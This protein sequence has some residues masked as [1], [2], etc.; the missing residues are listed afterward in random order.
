MCVCSPSCFLTSNG[1]PE[2]Q[3]QASSCC[4]H[5]WSLYT[6]GEVNKRERWW[7]FYI[8]PSYYFCQMREKGFQAWR[9]RSWFCEQNLAALFLPF[10]DVHFILGIRAEF[11]RIWQNR[12]GL[13]LVTLQSSPEEGAVGDRHRG[14]SQRVWKKPNEPGEPQV[15]GPELWV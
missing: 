2:L 5:W 14:T 13:R 9:N 15:R 10:P 1:L 7:I 11:G 8:W 4:H 12:Y 6:D 3:S